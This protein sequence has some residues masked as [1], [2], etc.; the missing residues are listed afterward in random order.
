M[1]DD[2]RLTVLNN[3][4]AHYGPQHWWE[5]KN[6]IY[7]LVSMILIQRTTSLNVDKALKNLAGKL[8]VDDL[9]AMSLEDL[10]IA[11]QPAGF[12]KQKAGYIKNIMNW[13][14]DHG[15]QI[16]NFI[17]I[18]TDELR[19]DILTIKGVG[20]ETA[21]VMLLYIFER[22][23]FVAD[24]YALRLFGRLDLGTFDSYM[25]MRNEFQHYTD[26]LNYQTVK[27]WHATI[28]EHG[29]RFRHDSKMDE[30]WLLIKE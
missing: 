26:N 9:R 21:D 4:N 13:I 11:I 17:D 2:K 25:E 5:Q 28:D 22:K 30:S 10:Q 3:L 7:V 15:N 19:K 1:L 18:P 23:V 27:E 20:N 14:F 8:S 6:K 24:T 12:Y 29:K 16:D